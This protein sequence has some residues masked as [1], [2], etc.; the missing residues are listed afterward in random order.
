MSPALMVRTRAKHR[1]PMPGEG[2][3]K[4][5]NEPDE[6]GAAGDDVIDQGDR[7]RG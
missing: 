7:L 5:R 2:I 3:L 6:A 4:M 1:M